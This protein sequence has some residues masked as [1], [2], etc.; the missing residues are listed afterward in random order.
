MS[1][2]QTQSCYDTCDT[3]AQREMTVFSDVHSDLGDVVGFAAGI[4][5]LELVKIGTI[6]R[7]A[8]PSR[9]DDAH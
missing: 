3:S 2:P 1:L 6:Q 9:R 8:W 5:L 4:T 7:L